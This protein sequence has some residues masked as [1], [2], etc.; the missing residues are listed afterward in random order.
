MSSARRLQFL[1]RAIKSVETR[2]SFYRE[3][4]G[5]GRE[6][7]GDF[8]IDSPRFAH[9]RKRMSGFSAPFNLPTHNSGLLRRAAQGMSYKSLL[10]WFSR[11]TSFERPGT[12]ELGFAHFASAKFAP[13]PDVIFRDLDGRGWMWT[14]E[15]IADMVQHL[16]KRAAQRGSYWEDAGNT[17]LEELEAWPGGTVGLLSMRALTQAYASAGRPEDAQ[18][19]Y[20][21]LQE[22]RAEQGL[23]PDPADDLALLQ[24]CARCGD[25]MGARAVLSKLDEEGHKVEADAGV[26]LLVE[27]YVTARGAAE[28]EQLL[29]RL[30]LC[31]E[32][33]AELVRECLSICIEEGSAE[34]AVQFAEYA[35]ERGVALGE[36]MRK[37]QGRWECVSPELRGRLARVLESPDQAGRVARML[38]V[39]MKGDKADVPRPGTPGVQSPFDALIVRSAELEAGD[40]ALAAFGAVE[41]FNATAAKRLRKERRMLSIEACQRVLA[42]ATHNQPL[43][44]DVIRKVLSHIGNFALV[45]DFATLVHL[46]A[47]VEASWD[48]AAEVAREVLAVCPNVD[49]RLLYYL[50]GWQKVRLRRK[51]CATHEGL[52]ALLRGLSRVHIP[53]PSWLEL[54]HAD[55]P[56]QLTQLPPGERLVLPGSGLSSLQVNGDEWRERGRRDN[57]ADQALKVTGRLLS[58]DEAPISSPDAG[59]QVGAV[60]PLEVVGVVEQRLVSAPHAS[61]GDLNPLDDTDKIAALARAV[62]GVTGTSVTV[63]CPKDDTAASDRLRSVC[64]D[65]FSVSSSL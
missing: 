32:V 27:G 49:D 12:Q 33:N 46:Q 48:R 21:M 16:T 41:R 55:L 35:T 39:W 2:A 51:P 10:N 61:E 19:V 18:R 17:V 60:Y 36:I 52:S 30:L 20:G 47:A 11:R 7:E 28:L 8:D 23:E 9:I 1:P 15:S 13:D 40:S 5:R 26:W 59:E 62:K 50:P 65:S 43:Q 58:S 38:E 56:A 25:I 37:R 53:L 64:G 45:I 14:D 4:D 31:S 54:S 6:S 42:A 29:P 44:V 22:R 57:P 63:L 24:G 34:A 3:S